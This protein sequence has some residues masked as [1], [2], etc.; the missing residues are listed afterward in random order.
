ME[1]IPG[2]NNDDS[3][4]NGEGFDN[5]ILYSANPG[6]PA[7]TPLDASRYH[8]SY[9]L[10]QKDAMGTENTQRSFSDRLYVAVTNKEEVV[11]LSLKYETPAKQQ[12]EIDVKVSY[13][14]PFEVVFLTPLANWNPYNIP[15][16]SD[17]TDVRGTGALDNPYT[18]TC[19]TLFFRTPQAV[20]TN[21]TQCGGGA[22]WGEEAY[23]F[24]RPNGEKVC[25]MASGIR[26]TIPPVHGQRGTIRQR[27]PIAGSHKDGSAAGKK[28]DAMEDS[29]SIDRKNLL[30]KI[31]LQTG[32]S[33]KTGNLQHFKSY[34]WE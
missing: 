3:P 28:L 16:E 27:F 12:K 8:R 23:F 33:T 21:S 31:S 14:M 10:G 1:E 4:I 25:L 29:I 9:K 6:K 5:L 17:C 32:V 15:H 20:F 22:V 19:P 7:Q 13:A 11:G 26:S 34:F 30:S 2:K 18:A 24:L